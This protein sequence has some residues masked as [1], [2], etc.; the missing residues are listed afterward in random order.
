MK[1]LLLAVPVFMLM[2]GSFVYAQPQSTCPI[3]GSKI[4][5]SLY[6]DHAGKR[7]YVCC[8]GCLTAVKANPEAVIAKLEAQGVEL[9][10]V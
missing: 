4:D 3:M 6:V 5:K 7:I 8:S 10:K 9:E 1:K 2:A